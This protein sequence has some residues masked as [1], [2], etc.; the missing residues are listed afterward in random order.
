MVFSLE[1]PVLLFPLSAAWLPLLMC[2]HIKYTYIDRKHVTFKA[3]SGMGGE[4][5]FFTGRGGAGK[6]SKFG[7]QDGPGR[8]TP[9]SPQDGAGRGTPPPHGEGSHWAGRPS[10]IGSL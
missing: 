1:A 6:E 3:I 7:E 4:A 2:I 5:F 10:L 8:G 9:P